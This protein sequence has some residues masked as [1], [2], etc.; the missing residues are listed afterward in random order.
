MDV[1]D[2]QC[3]AVV[4]AGLMGHGIAQEFALAGYQVWLHSRTQKSLDTALDNITAN[5]DRLIRLGVV[6]PPQAAAVPKR[7][8]TSPHLETAVS[9]A[10]VVIESVYEDADLKR[11]I[12]QELDAVCPDRTILASNTSTLMLSQ[13]ATAT[14]RPDKLVISHYANPPY[15]IPIVELVRGATTSDET[16]ETMRALLTPGRQ[17]SGRGPKRSARI[18]SQP[19]PG[20]AAARGAVA[21]PGRD[22]QSPGHRYGPQ[23]QYRPPLGGGRYLRGV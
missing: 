9:R 14:Q 22:C 12:F 7:I 2:I 19:T 20:S 6:S 11:R 5:L 1:D 17:A 23:E 10:D 15:L 3:I 8:R 21:G 18:Y 4:G 16:V 13:F